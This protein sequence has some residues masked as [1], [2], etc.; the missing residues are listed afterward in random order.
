MKRKR[1]AAVTLAAAAGVCGVFAAG[2]NEKDD[3]LKLEV[4]VGITNYEPMDYQEDGV[5]KGFDYEL[6]TLVFDS[7][8]YAPEFKVIEWDTKLVA[9]KGYEIDVIWN[10]M[11]VTEEL[12]DNLLLSD[13]YLQ[14]RQYGVVKTENAGTYTSAASLLGAKV[15]VE[16]GSAANGLMEDE[17]GTLNC[18][19]LVKA[20]DQN[21]AI[22]EVASGASDVAIVDY[23][24]AVSMTESAE[25]S[26]YGKLKAV[27]LGFEAENFAVGF[28]TA[29]TELCRKVNEKIKEFYENGKVKELA[30]KYGIENQLVGQ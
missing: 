5:W 3:D 25:S 29:D 1:I 18:E 24:L 27:D 28:R 12:E 16:A 15:A 8:G 10:G 26:Y 9:L 30:V 11:T 22:L 6:A 14:N 20:A 7:L 19:E 23:L 17:D 13:T 21:A 2:C 4:V